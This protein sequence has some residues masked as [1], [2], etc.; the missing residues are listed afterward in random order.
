MI[1]RRW[2]TPSNNTIERAAGWHS[3]AAAAQRAR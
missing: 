3:L 1:Y 2:R